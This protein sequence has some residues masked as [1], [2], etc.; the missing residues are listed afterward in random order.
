MWTVRSGLA[1]VVARGQ[2]SLGC[3]AFWGKTGKVLPHSVATAAW[4][5]R[6]P[7]VEG[8]N[9]AGLLRERGG[10]GGQQMEGEGEE[11]G[12]SEA[13]HGLSDVGGR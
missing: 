9:A 10:V 3:G 7:G 4:P 6:F 5:V 8:L 1:T 2:R 13:E 11:E 12:V